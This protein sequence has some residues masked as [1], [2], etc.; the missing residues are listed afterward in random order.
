MADRA[1]G[2]TSIFRGPD[3]RASTPLQLYLIPHLGGPK[4]EY[5]HLPFIVDH[6]GERLAKRHQSLGLGALREA[7]VRP[8]AVLGCLAGWSGL[9]EVISP[10][11]A[12]EL[13]Q[14]EA[15]RLR[16]PE[17]ALPPDA[18]KILLKHSR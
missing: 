18:L 10:I 13:A 5:A 15:A 17:V 2:V 7:G 11:E 6:E 14:L 9:S 12:G 1:A 16:S 3:I 4:P 8:Q